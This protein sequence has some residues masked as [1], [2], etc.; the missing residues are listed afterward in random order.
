VN[1]E[2]LVR[3]VPESD[4]DLI[5]DGKACGGDCSAAGSGTPGLLALCLAGL[6]F[7]RRR[8]RS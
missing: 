1:G 8:E 4:A 3:A 6:V 2:Y 5:D 7:I